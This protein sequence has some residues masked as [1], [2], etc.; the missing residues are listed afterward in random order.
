MRS[1]IEKYGS[2]EKSQPILLRDG[3][4]PQ[5]AVGGLDD[6]AKK[7]PN[8]FGRAFIPKDGSVPVGWFLSHSIGNYKWIFTVIDNE[9]KAGYVKPRK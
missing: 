5:C 8:N 3:V 4:A 1:N 6:K 9:K 7:L 2:D